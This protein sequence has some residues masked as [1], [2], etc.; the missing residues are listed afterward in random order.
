MCAGHR[1]G[2]FFTATRARLG[3]WQELLAVEG[4]S[5]AAI[6]EGDHAPATGASQ[7]PKSLQGVH[8]WFLSPTKHLL[9]HIQPLTRVWKAQAK[10]ATKL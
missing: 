9:G 5:L 8:S 3:T 2:R 1:P 7:G 10:E 4:Q 6:E